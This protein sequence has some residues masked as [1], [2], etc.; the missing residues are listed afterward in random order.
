MKNKLINFLCILFPLIIILLILGYFINFRKKQINSIKEEKGYFV[1]MSPV[2]NVKFKKVPTKILTAQETYNDILVSFNKENGI[3]AV[4]SMDKFFDDFYK[5]LNIIPKIDK[6]NI[7]QISVGRNMYDKELFYSLNADIHHIDPVALSLT[8]G[9]KPSDI[10]EISNNIGPFFANRYSIENK[11]PLHL[12]DYKFYTLE[13]IT[14]K[15]GEVYKKEDTAKKLNKFTKNLIKKIQ[16]KLP[17]NNKKTIAIVYLCR[18][19]IVPFDSESDGYGLSQYKILNC[20]D[21]F[22]SK[23]IKTYSYEGNFGT[24]LDKETLLLANP[25]II[26]INEGV[27]I[28]DKYRFFSKRTKLLINEFEKFKKDPLLKDIP[29]FKNNK[30]ILGGIYDQGPII[31]IYQLEML[32][33]QL[34]PEIFGIFRNNHSYLE[35]E[36]L[37]SRDE[38]RKIIKDEQN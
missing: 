8:K 10:N 13:E 14:L 34:Y 22:K 27:Y 6:N 29:A 25:D 32:A 5:D 12:K 9:W 18:K 28:N 37:F 1:K 24:M 21:A 2:G 11:K 3:S 38:L 30:I 35:N 26:I 4:G 23:G 36:Q 19:G 20:K 7:I 15:F 16:N 31:R 33:K 17:K